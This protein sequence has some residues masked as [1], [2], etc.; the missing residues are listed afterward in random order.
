MCSQQSVGTAGHGASPFTS[1]IIQVLVGPNEVRFNVHKDVICNASQFFNVCLNIGMVEART[2]V[3]KLPEDDPQAFD[4]A[5]HFVYG[6]DIAE[7]ESLTSEA[8]KELVAMYITADKLDLEMLGN[9]IVDIIMSEHRGVTTSFPSLIL[10]LTASPLKDFMIKQL[11]WDLQFTGDMWTHPAMAAEL[12]KFFL[13]GAPEVP[14]VLRMQHAVGEENYRLPPS[15]GW[16]C[17]YH[18]HVITQK[19][20]SNWGWD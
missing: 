3:V 20:K 1:E 12:D 18:K 19:C 11:A 15:R 7:P 14:E 4:R 8:V 13:T 17:K 9:S 5:L 2:N 10:G 16:K 6:E